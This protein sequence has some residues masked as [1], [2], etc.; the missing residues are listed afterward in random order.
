VAD[1][2]KN[3]EDMSETEVA[4]FLYEQWLERGEEFAMEQAKDV[5]RFLDEQKRV[6]EQAEAAEGQSVYIRMWA[7]FRKKRTK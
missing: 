2:R 3:F 4:S 1:E 7:D 5:K 6:K